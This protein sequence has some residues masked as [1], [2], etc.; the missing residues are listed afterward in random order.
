MA[1]MVTFN[2]PAAEISTIAAAILSVVGLL[3]LYQ[4]CKPMDIWRRIIWTAMAVLL[5]VC[6]TTLQG[7]FSLHLD[8]NA[9]KL[10]AGT[11]LIMTPTVFFFFQR[12]FDIGDYITHKIRHHKE[13]EA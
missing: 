13:K 10:L 6:F 2:L 4:I 5:M 8:T 11:L 1:F 9:G 12:V 7:T 3:V